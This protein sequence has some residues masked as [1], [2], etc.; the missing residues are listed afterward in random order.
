MPRAGGSLE[1]DRVREA[2]D[3][4]SLIGEHVRLEQKG[5]EHVGLCPFHD[6]RSPSM[7]VVTHKGPGFY[8]CFACGASGDCFT[9][10][11]EY[12]R[13]GFGEALQMLADR[14]GI[15]LAPRGRDGRN[16]PAGPG[17]A[18]MLEAC[19]FALDLYRSILGHPERGREGRAVIER[20]GISAE[21]V[22]A[23][24][25]GFA[26]PGFDT[27]RRRVEADGPSMKAAVAA[28]LLRT[29]A[30][31]GTYDAF[32]HRLIFPI[33]D[34]MGRP[35]AFG[36]RAVAPDDEP[37]YLNSP[38]TR[39]FD[40]S[41]TLFGLHLARPAIVEAGA[42]IVTEGYTDVV[43]CHQAGVRNV[44]GTMGTALT[45]AHGERLAR[46]ADTVILVFDGD[47]AGQ[48]AAD[49]AVRVFF[50]SR[51]DVKVCGLPEG[52]DPDELLRE[53]GA[54]GFRDL[55]DG[56][57]DALAWKLER[58]RAAV[59]PAAGI[60]A[61]Q[62]ALEDFLGELADLGFGA[63][64]PVRRQLVLDHLQ[65]LLHVPAAELEARL[66]ELERDAESR[67]RRRAERD[68]AAAKAA[69]A[70]RPPARAAADVP[71]DADG[72]PLVAPADVDVEA[73]PH[74]VPYDAAPAIPADA[75]AEVASVAAPATAHGSRARHAAEREL[76]ALALD[77]PA[78]LRAAAATV[79]ADPAWAARL[80]TAVGGE[81][82]PPSS[83]A[84]FLAPVEG[85]P[86][87]V[88]DPASAAV[89]RRL[90]A[91]LAAP[92]AAEPPGAGAIMDGVRGED[93][94][95]RVAAL[96]FDGERLAA[97]APEPGP[98]AILAALEALV[99]IL[100]R[101]HADRTVSAARRD[102][103]SGG[104]DAHDLAA[105][106]ETRRREGTRPA[107][108][109]RRPDAFAPRRSGRPRGYPDPPRPF[110]P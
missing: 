80:G 102:A 87:T 50:R 101:D 82:A 96:H 104:V 100:E 66:T 63:M 29:R 23:F 49:R 60:S 26:P 15:P 77:D 9:F 11:Q 17:R 47:E 51:V 45:E 40:K 33:C 6:D 59:D 13:V 83:L 21:M 37:K 24:G 107:A 57:V 22:E 78:A 7:H 72:R 52:R 43:A 4:V 74:D 38:E 32:R 65:R 14:A 68:A 1:V 27:L 55:V 53:R 103:A 44:V 28:G 5:R 92:D 91:W 106:I 39:I 19:R 34:D 73:E 61:R 42:T 98:P 30:G 84:A 69:A 10:V 31:G 8:K 90:G 94:R 36:A 48:R 2:T 71:I 93:V 95:A 62:K 67:R 89:A 35:I 3:L 56:A 81:T 86:P 20:R 88:R 108:I 46:H 99:R 41:R 16:G 105:I 12:H 54:D 58:F 70:A 18:E 25:L 109:A 64:S 76:A 85:A 97:A 110:R 79:D 75:D